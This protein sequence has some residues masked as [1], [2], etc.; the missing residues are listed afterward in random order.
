M[1]SPHGACILPGVLRFPLAG[2]PVEIHPTFLILGLFVLDANFGGIGVLLWMAAA[3]LSILIHELGHAFTAKWAGG[4]VERVM[5]YGMGGVTMWTD[6]A[7]RVDWWRRILVSLAGSLSGFVVG[8]A[9]YAAIRAGALGPLAE[10]VITT[11]WDVFLG[12]WV[13]QQD[14]LVFFLATLVWASVVWGALNLLPIGGLD[15]SHVLTAFLER[16][17][18][19]HGRTVGVLIGLAVAIVAAVWLFQRGFTFAPLVFVY[20]ALNDLRRLQR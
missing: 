19:R 3:F 15:G 20:F 11:P 6:P 5:L 14:W 2:F 18:P 16:I 12:F 17:H 1:L 8:G 7:G 9:A 4:R 10:Q 13:E